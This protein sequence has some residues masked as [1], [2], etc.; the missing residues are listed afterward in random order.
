MQIT[1][2]QNLSEQTCHESDL[3]EDSVVEWFGQ[4]T[5]SI[6]EFPKWGSALATVVRVLVYC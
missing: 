2:P 1:L 4:P 6:L 3:L 5:F